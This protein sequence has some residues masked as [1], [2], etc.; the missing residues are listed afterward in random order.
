[1]LV[2]VVLSDGRVA[3]AAD[4]IEV[5][6]E[7]VEVA[8]R[9]RV[10]E[11]RFRFASPCLRGGCEQWAEGQCGVIGRVMAD[12]RRDNLQRVLPACSIRSNCRWFEQEAAAACAVC[13]LVITD[14]RRE[15]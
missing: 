2:G 13:P 11:K 10:P 14:M 4:R 7:F 12:T 1:V 15:T 5:D 8:R 9:G 3:F 6:A